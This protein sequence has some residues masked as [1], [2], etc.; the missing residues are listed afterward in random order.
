MLVLAPFLR[1]NYFQWK[2]RFVHMGMQD[3]SYSKGGTS[4]GDSAI[5]G[6]SLEPSF[7]TRWMLNRNSLTVLR[8]LLIQK[9]RFRRRGRIQIREKLPVVLDVEN[10]CSYNGLLYGKN[11]TGCRLILYVMVFP[12]ELFCTV[13]FIFTCEVCEW[14]CSAMKNY[15]TDSSQGQPWGG[16]IPS[17]SSPWACQHPVQI[18]GT[19]KASLLLSYMGCSLCTVSPK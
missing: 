15:Q 2:G 9:L 16:A 10:P 6:L 13:W 17:H 18:D 14:S 12:C 1:R 5:L 19:M 7:G 4:M 11:T 3:G 8:F